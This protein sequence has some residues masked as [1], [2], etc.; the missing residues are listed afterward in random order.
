MASPGKQADGLLWSRRAK[1]ECL[2][3]PNGTSATGK[4]HY[5]DQIES[6]QVSYKMKVRQDQHTV[7]IESIT[8]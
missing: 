3:V 6:E 1:K 8:K 5:S 4:K 2:E 7:L